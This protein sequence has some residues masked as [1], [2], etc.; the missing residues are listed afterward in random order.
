M[1]KA[2]EL[3]KQLNGQPALHLKYNTSQIKD[4]CVNDEGN[5]KHRNHV[6]RANPILHQK[7]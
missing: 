4:Y 1:T 3:S 7:N 2:L 5:S 6:F